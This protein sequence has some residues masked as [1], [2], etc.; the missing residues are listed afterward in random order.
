MLPMRG[1]RAPPMPALPFI[2]SFRAEPLHRLGGDCP[3]DPSAEEVVDY[4]FD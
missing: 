4:D 2:T 3:H 1:T